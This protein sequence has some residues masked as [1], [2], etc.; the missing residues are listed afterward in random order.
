M[1]FTSDMSTLEAL[2]RLVSFCKKHQ[3]AIVRVLGACSGAHLYGAKGLA[4]LNVD[5]R[6]GG[7]SLHTVDIEA[8]EARAPERIADLH[9]D[10]VQLEALMAELGATF[11][12][13]VPF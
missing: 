8:Y 4:Y 7:C 9:A 5:L 10:C 11:P 2:E 13:D 1:T 12:A 6:Q 3:L